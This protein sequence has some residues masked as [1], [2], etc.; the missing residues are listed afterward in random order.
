MYIFH[1]CDMCNIQ[2]E[3]IDDFVCQTCFDIL[4]EECFP[5]EP[6]E[7]EEPEPEPEQK[8]RKRT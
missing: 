8:K 4:M 2:L 5:S 1:Y 3:N 7:P 6:T